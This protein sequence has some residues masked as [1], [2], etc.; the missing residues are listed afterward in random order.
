MVS[1]ADGLVPGNVSIEFIVDRLANRS[2]RRQRK[3]RIVGHRRIDRPCR[4]DHAAEAKPSAVEFAQDIRI[5]DRNAAL[6]RRA[7]CD[8]RRNDAKQDQKETRN[9]TRGLFRDGQRRGN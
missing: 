1:F 5:G 4:L 8:A 7:L 3:Q 9:C 2:H 6:Q